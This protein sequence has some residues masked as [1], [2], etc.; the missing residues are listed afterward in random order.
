[1]VDFYVSNRIK[2]EGVLNSLPT[3]LKGKVNMI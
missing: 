2:L 3:I 1:M